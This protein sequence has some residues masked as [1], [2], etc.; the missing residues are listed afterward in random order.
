MT[1]NSSGVTG[2]DGEPLAF[3]QEQHVLIGL[4]SVFHSLKGATND[5][6]SRL[7]GNNEV[8]VTFILINSDWYMQF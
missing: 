5:N 7:F 8:S 1:W 3:A 4:Q 2:W 6:Q